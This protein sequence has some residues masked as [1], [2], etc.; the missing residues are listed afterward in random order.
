VR[1]FLCLSSH[2]LILTPFTRLSKLLGDVVISQGGV[3]PHVSLLEPYRDVE[4]KPDLN[5]SDRSRTLAHKDWE[6]QEGFSG[7]LDVLLLALYLSV[8]FL[9]YILDLFESCKM[10]V[11]ITFTINQFN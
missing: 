9:Y 3:V 7:G 6:G 2:S 5:D 8:L 1:L 10:L 11:Q 4:P